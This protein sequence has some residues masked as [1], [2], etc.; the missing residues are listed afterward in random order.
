VIRVC[1]SPRPSVNQ[2]T[3]DG[4]GEQGVGGA[5]EPKGAT[6]PALSVFSLSCCRLRQSSPRRKRC[7]AGEV[8]RR[9]GG[10]Q[11]DGGTLV[12]VAVGQ[13]WMRLLERRPLRSARL[14]RVRPPV[15][16]EWNRST[17]IG[18]GGTGRRLDTEVRHCEGLGRGRRGAGEGPGARSSRS[19]EHSARRRHWAP[20]GARFPAFTRGSRGRRGLQTACR[21]GRA[22]SRIC[23]R[24]SSGS[25]TSCLSSGLPPR[26]RAPCSH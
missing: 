17:R 11:R 18:H 4:P 14:A 24:S 6:S 9:A 10:R 20:L 7:R 3:R 25:R 23:R 22:P 12:Q 15:G 1:L 8:H 5:G 2:F 19:G 21:T 13:T 26:A 16:V